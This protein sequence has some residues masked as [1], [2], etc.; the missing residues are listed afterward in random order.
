[1]CVAE[2]EVDAYE[3]AATDWMY[4]RGKATTPRGHPVKMMG[5]PPIRQRRFFVRIP[6]HT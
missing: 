1:M 6:E 4:E 2:C 3:R 5:C